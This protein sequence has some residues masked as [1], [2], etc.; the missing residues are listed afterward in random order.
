MPPSDWRTRFTVT[1]AGL[2]PLSRYENTTP[3]CDPR[4]HLAAEV[5]VSIAGEPG[6]GVSCTCASGGGGGRIFTGLLG[7]DWTPPDAIARTGPVCASIGT[8][9]KSV[10]AVCD[11]TAA[12][13]AALFEP[14]PWNTTF[15]T[16]PRF[17]P[18]I[19]AVAPPWMSR[20]AAQPFT[21]ATVVTVGC[22]V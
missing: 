1:S 22:G 2:D 7:A 19:F 12:D 21:H 18:L 11:L 20:F 10:V 6:A 8:G 13:F 3:R 16:A 9:T 15:V 17:W 5:A 14:L 4:N